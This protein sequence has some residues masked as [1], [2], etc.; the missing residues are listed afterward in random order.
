MSYGVKLS[1]AVLRRLVDRPR[2]DRHRFPARWRQGSAWGRRGAVVGRVMLAAGVVA[3]AAVMALDARIERQRLA[4]TSTDS[5]GTSSSVAALASQGAGPASGATALTSP[6]PPGAATPAVGGMPQLPPA[7]PDLPQP[8]IGSVVVPEMDVAVA[9]GS[10][11]PATKSRPG[12]A[13]Q[14]TRPSLEALPMT[15]MLA[16]VTVGAI[17]AAVGLW[18]RRSRLS[19][20]RDATEAEPAMVQDVGNPGD[21]TGIDGDQERLFPSPADV[22]EVLGPDSADGG[23]RRVVQDAP[24]PLHGG[25]EGAEEV[26]GADPERLIVLGASPSDPTAEEPADTTT[27][28]ADSGGRQSPTFDR[29]ANQTP[30]AA[31]GSTRMLLFSAPHPEAARNADL[32]S[33]N[34]SPVRGL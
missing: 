22:L 32:T 9:W 4:D 8:D 3:V 10:D 2:R 30:P 26:P 12:A 16:V 20:D 5:P 21:A 27:P 19:Q 1:P 28:V 18:R 7:A 33:S 13:G 6:Q 11:T 24:E 25:V 31:E 17:A 29:A 34:A 14:G 15:V 23:P